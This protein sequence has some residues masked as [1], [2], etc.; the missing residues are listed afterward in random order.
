MLTLGL[1]I[2]S[3]HDLLQV[4][5]GV[6]KPIWAPYST[7]NSVNWREFGASVASGAVPGAFAGAVVGARAGTPWAGAAGGA[8]AGGLA[9]GMGYCI[10][11]M[12]NGIQQNRPVDPS[13][14]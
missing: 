2:L 13:N 8:A 1:A 7:I 12:V 9:G 11:T 5:G 4:I 14:I 10:T 6:N 3:D